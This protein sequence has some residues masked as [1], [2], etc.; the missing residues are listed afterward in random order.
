M[1]AQHAA[2]SLPVPTQAELEAWLVAK[3]AALA[4]LDVADVDPEA[5]FASNGLD[6][7]AT[8]EIGAELETWLGRRLPA[9]LVWD[10]PTIRALAQHLSKRLHG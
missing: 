5:D 6:S 9:T 3:T 4:N 10:H 8:A 2:A 7:V 1:N